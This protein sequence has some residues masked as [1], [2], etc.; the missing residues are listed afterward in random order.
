MYAAVVALFVTAFV[1]P[2]HVQA[3]N[4][5]LLIGGKK[6]T[7]ENCGDLTAIDGVK[8]KAKYDPA[9]NTLTLDNATITT[10]AEKAAGVGLWNSIKDLKVVLIGENT[11]T[12]EKSG[13][14][15]NYDKLT[16][17]GAGKLTITGAMSGNEDY[18]YG[19]L[20]PGTVTV[21]G[22]TLEI[23]GGVNGITSGRW[24]FN[25][26]NV[27][28]KGNGTTKDEYKGSMGRLGYV[29]EFT[30]CKITAPAGAEWKELKKS[31]YTFQSLFANGKVVTDWVTIKPNAAPENYNILICG[32]RVT[33][34]NCG[35]LTAIEGVKGKAA[36]DPATNT[37]TFDNATIT[38][39][40][41]K[42]AGVGL[43]T[44]VKGLTIKLIGENTI[45]SEKSGGMVNY[46][47]L[48]FTGAGKLTINGA[49]S[50]NEDYCYGILNPGTITVDGCSLEISGG[51]NGITSG[52]WKFNKCNV[53]VK[54][55]G[56]EKD[57]YKGSMGRL[58]YV[59][60]FTDCKIVS[61]EGTE[62]KELKKGSYTFQSLFGSNGKVVTDWVTIQPND[63][64]ETYDLVLESYG[65]NLIA[66]TKIV[67]ELTGLTLLK[68]KQLVES[69]P[70]IIKENMSQE[71]AKEARD[72]L[73]AAGATASIHLHGTWKPSGI[74]VQ[75]VDTAAKI[76]YTLQ[77][78]RLN[79]KF[80]NLPAGVY[81]VN[82]K[83]VLKK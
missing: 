50:G 77:G 18:C 71:E 52:R 65:D 3:E 20:N 69:A 12:S 32:Q 11:I 16:F 70:C 80:E 68:A 51:V 62:W 58:G 33:S 38:T 17:T 21:D 27:R 64:P 59:P 79:T 23:S 26:C 28:V 60:E 6:V 54:G 40:A 4:Y 13:G 61:P 22:C 34:E 55:N 57:E 25:K 36:F 53:R 8:G 19:V 44:S 81:I 83:K 15:V 9:S 47:K 66:V 74:N 75:T 49:M 14:M 30:D 42:A 10:T 82:G 78:V 31:G 67:K 5:N 45:T 56:T 46:E 73:L 39:T 72:K 24:K 35:D 76:I 29:P 43:W 41:E 63:A 7:S 37:L 1:L 2:Q 48:T